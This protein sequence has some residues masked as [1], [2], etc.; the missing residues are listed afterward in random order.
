MEIHEIFL[1]NYICFL[2]IS[3]SR[4][5]HITLMHQLVL[6]LNLTNKCSPDHYFWDICTFQ[7]DGCVSAALWLLS[8]WNVQISPS[9]RTR[10][11][12]QSKRENASDAKHERQMRNSTNFI[13]F[14]VIH[15]ST[16]MSS[17]SSTWKMTT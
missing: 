2:Q 16:L 17:Q 4:V 11:G 5:K 15:F 14:K 8:S 9:R 6:P 10:V 1:K 13:E 7:S 12:I 3:H